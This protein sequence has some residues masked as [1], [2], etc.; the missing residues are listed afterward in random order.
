MCLTETWQQPRVYLSLTKA[1][2]K[3]YTYMDKARSTGYGGGLAILHRVKL[4]LTPLPLP[5]SLYLSA[6]L[7][8]ANPRIP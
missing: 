5:S 8:S 6:L 3:G 4:N 7:H 2:P 1:C